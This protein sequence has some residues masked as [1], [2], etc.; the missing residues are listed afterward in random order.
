MSG[1]SDDPVMQ[2]PKDYGF[3]ASICKP[4]MKRGLSE[5]LNRNMKT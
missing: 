3:A 4:F 1:Y 5:M 2:N